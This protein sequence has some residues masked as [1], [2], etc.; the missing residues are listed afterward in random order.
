MYKFS[1]VSRI[2]V[3]R[4]LQFYFRM[5]L[6]TKSKSVQKNQE[7]NESVFYVPHNIFTE[8]GE[9][10]MNADARQSYGIHLADEVR[11]TEW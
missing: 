11:T 3:G 6:K 9:N 8:H 1:S 4:L 10:E 5:I 2:P 7:I